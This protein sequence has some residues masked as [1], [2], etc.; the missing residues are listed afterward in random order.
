MVRDAVDRYRVEVAAALDHERDE[1]EGD[2]ADSPG[3]LPAALGGKYHARGRESGQPVTM[4]IREHP[5][6]GYEREFASALQP[7]AG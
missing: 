2:P 4:T 6:R 7:A 3:D 1:G 5:V